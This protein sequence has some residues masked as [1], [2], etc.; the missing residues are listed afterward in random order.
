PAHDRFERNI[1]NRFRRKLPL[2]SEN[3]GCGSRNDKGRR[4]SEMSAR[5]MKY[6]WDSTVPRRLKHVLVKLAFHAN[7]DGAQVFPSAKT[8][9][10]ACGL[11]ERAVRSIL[12]QLRKMGVIEVTEP[13]DTVTKKPTVYRIVVSALP[14]LREAR[15]RRF[16]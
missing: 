15:R 6:V 5:F 8:L 12:S 10:R 9:A 7:E 4:S 1:G 11:T 14:G 13:A 3:T 16:Q 2:K